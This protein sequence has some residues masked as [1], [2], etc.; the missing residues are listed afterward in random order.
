[1]GDDGVSP[2]VPCLPGGPGRVTVLPYRVCQGDR[3]VRELLGGLVEKH[4]P[5][6]IRTCSQYF[7]LLLEY[8]NMVGIRYPG[9]SIG[10]EGTG[11]GLPLGS[12]FV[13]QFLN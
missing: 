9:H 10:R 5:D 12:I 13:G 6:S 3:D 8:A 11:G 4:F 2:A 7:S 1:M